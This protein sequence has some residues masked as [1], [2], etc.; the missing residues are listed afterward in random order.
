M[1]P[2]TLLPPSF[3][4]SLSVGP[5]KA[6]IGLDIGHTRL[7]E[8][9][10]NGELESYKDGRSRKITVRSIE[11]YLERKLEAE[12]AYRA[13][14]ASSGAANLTEI[15]PRSSDAHASTPASVVV[16][17]GRKRGRPRKNATMKRLTAAEVK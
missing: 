4:D 5:R 7:Y 2:R 8:L 13:A 16:M 14:A 15:R 10:N 3:F 9:V 17:R 1:T 12:R 6:Q 11:A